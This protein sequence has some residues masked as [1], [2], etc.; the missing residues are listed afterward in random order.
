MANMKKG[1][2]F[3]VPMIMKVNVVNVVLMIT[4]TKVKI[5]NESALRQRSYCDR[6]ELRATGPIA[7]IL[8][9]S[10]LSFA[11]GTVAFQG[12]IICTFLCGALC[13]GDWGSRIGPT[14]LPE[15]WSSRILEHQGAL[16]GG[17]WESRIGPTPL[18]E[19]CCS[20]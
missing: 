16:C 7:R 5:V 15:Q 13:G 11:E 18:P 8:K 17:D 2:R 6:S 3:L 19:Q 20:R 1:G 12:V 9:P 10:L 14:A 4:I